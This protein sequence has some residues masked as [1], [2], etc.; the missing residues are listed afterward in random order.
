MTPIMIIFL[1][2]ALYII[3]Q[4][5]TTNEVDKWN[6]LEEWIECKQAYWQ[7]LTTAQQE[8]IRTLNPTQTVPTRRVFIGENGETN[9]TTDDSVTSGSSVEPPH[10]EMRI[11]SL[12]EVDNLYDRGWKANLVDALWP[13][14][15]TGDLGTKVKTN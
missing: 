6:D 8:I 12:E 10:P 14:P 4:G 5:A 9:T 13:K 15:F 7:P 3:S 11:L 1:G 2:Y